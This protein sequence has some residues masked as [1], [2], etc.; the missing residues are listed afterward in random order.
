MNDFEDI[1]V[2]MPSEFTKPQSPADVFIMCDN[3]A[4]IHFLKNHIKE[5][6]SKNEIY[7]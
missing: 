6:I 2:V 3:C 4:T 1:A 5:R 7:S